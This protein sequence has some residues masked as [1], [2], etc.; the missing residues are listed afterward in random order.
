MQQRVVSLGGNCMVTM[1]MRKFFGIK[2]ANLFDWW[3]TP[4]DALVRLIESDF[5]DLFAPENL[6]M[7]GGQRSVANVRYGILH[8]HDFPRNDTEDLV[9]AITE[10]DMQR[11][12]EK[13][14]YLKK[15]WDELGDNAGPVLFIRWGWLMGEPL[16]A[17]IPPAPIGADAPRLIAALD[18]KFPLLDYKVL[19]IDCPELVLDQ[20]HP[21]IM[22]LRS[23]TFTQ[24]GEC[25]NAADLGWKDNSAIFSRLF[26]T[27]GVR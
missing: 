14:A 5:A 18:R 15:R 3:I 19:F 12:R 21:K 25:L 24:P 13:F 11:N 1:E 7:V 8:H 17:G 22:A 27:L 20:E 6:Q 9:V 23:G 4:G 2:A 16:L 26:A 10:A